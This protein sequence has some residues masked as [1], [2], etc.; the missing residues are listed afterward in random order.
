MFG[1][2]SKKEERYDTLRTS[3]G[4]LG[5]LGAGVMAYLTYLHYSGVSSLCDFGEGF[6]C[7]TVNQSTFSEILGVPVAVL[8]LVYFLAVASLLVFR[9]TKGVFTW[10]LLGSVFSI[11]FGIYLSA[12]EHFVLESICLYCE[13]SKLVMIAI[14]GVSAEGAKQGGEDVP[15]EW[16]AWT[17]VLALVFS[18]GAWVVQR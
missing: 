8:G 17:V 4:L 16:V 11:A 7:S 9:C 2:R 12:V 5:V 3:A 14:I 15:A 10:V 1:F 18:Y 6:S 13:M